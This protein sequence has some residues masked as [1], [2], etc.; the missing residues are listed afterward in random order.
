VE[1]KYHFFLACTVYEW[2]LPLLRSVVQS[3]CASW[4]T[5]S[6]SDVIW[7]PTFSIYLI[8]FTWT[9]TMFDCGSNYIVMSVKSLHTNLEQLWR[10]ACMYRVRQKTIPCS[11]D[12]SVYICWP[13]SAMFCTEYTELISNT[14]H[15][16]LSEGGPLDREAQTG[17]GW[18]SIEFATLYLGNGAR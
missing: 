10:M 9:F 5:C 15:V 12:Y 3:L 7:S 6:L 13:I 4:A 17:V 14:K 8:L 16:D 11:F 1:N 2:S 18:F